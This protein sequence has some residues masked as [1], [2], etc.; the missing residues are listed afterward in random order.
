MHFYIDPG[1][2]SMLFT[3]LIG[4]IGAVF[5]SLRNVLI[6]LRFV[7]SGGKKGEVSDDRMPLVIFT[8]SKRY[9]NVF[10]PICDELERR[11]VEAQY[12]TMSPDDPALSKD[13]EHITCR[14]IGEGNGAFAKMNLLNAGIVL[15]S[16]PGL[17]VYQWKRS[18]NVQ[19]YVHIPH[20]CTDVTIYR[21]FG[22]DYYDAVL[23]SGQYQ[24]D[25][26]RQLETL[27]SLPGKDLRLVGVTYMDE[28][29]R[30]LEQAPPLPEHQR[31][32]LLAPS[33]GPSA[34]FSRYGGRIIDALLDTGYHIVI[35]PHPQSFTSEKEL[36]DELMAAY[37]DSD[38]LEWNRDNDNFDVLRRSDV[39][40]SDFSGVIFDFA[41][42]YDKPVIYADVSFDGAPYDCCWLEEEPWT[43]R[44]LPKIGVPLAEGSLPQLK[45]II[46]S[47]IDE[48]RFAEAR[49]Q[50]RKD[51]WVCI[52]QAA[53]NVADY[54]IEKQRELD[55]APEADASEG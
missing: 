47:A 39:M 40:I 31:T 41:L 55:S 45:Q 20:M 15:S 44:V 22:L 34:V 9:W 46:D 11:G 35:R 1:T 25:Q 23:L 16:T 17:D 5:Y 18:K 8:D 10:E 52:G 33:W 24:I 21:M 51:A 36:L 50:A 53:G 42:I 13:Y 49:E 26:T 19:W 38:R 4:V 37:P 43:F 30:R 3:I 7:M 6:K 54:L 12:L 48:E 2:G 27:R 14:F 28:L 29:K 32:V